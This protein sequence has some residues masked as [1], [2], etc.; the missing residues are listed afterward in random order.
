MLRMKISKE[1]AEL[2]G[3]ILGDGHVHK[4]SDTIVVT[5]SLDDYEY[6]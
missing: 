3:V 1:L 5:G 4:I 6:Y 2:I